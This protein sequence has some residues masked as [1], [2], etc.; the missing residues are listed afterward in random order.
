[1]PLLLP[2][3]HKEPPGSLLL[4]VVFLVFVGLGAAVDVYGPG[5]L[6]RYHPDLMYWSAVFL[7]VVILPALA[8]AAVRIAWKA[9]ARRQSR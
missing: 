7:V 6:L 9:L 1:M 8:M 2:G 5:R 3:P 4:L